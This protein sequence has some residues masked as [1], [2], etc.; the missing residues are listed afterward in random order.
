L[1]LIGKQCSRLQRCAAEAWYQLSADQG[2]IRGQNNLSAL[3]EELEAEGGGDSA[4]EPVSDP[5][6]ETV[7][8]RA[9]IRDLRAQITRRETDALTDENSAYELAH[10]GNNGKK[11]GGIAKMMDAIRTVAAQTALVPLCLT[12]RD[13]R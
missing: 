13:R 5:V 10:M 12:G 2:N 3:Q 8:R 4:N 7:K 11:N 1:Q 9:R 6:I